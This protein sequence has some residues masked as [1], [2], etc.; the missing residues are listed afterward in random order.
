MSTRPSRSRVARWASAA[1]RRVCAEEGVEPFFPATSQR[2]LFFFGECGMWVV[3]SW[4]HIGPTYFGP[5]DEYVVAGGD[6]RSAIVM[7]LG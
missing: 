7:Y 3:N 5:R 1:Q 2:K 4:Y 6:S